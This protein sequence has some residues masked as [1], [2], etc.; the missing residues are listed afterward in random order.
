M[1]FQDALDIKKLGGFAGYQKTFVGIKFLEW[2]VKYDFADF[3]LCKRPK[4]TKLSPFKVTI[5][6]SIL[7]ITFGHL[8]QKGY[9]F[10]Y[11]LILE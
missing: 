6:I 5:S 1:N 8:M 3:N 10:L 11:I 4:N 2:P 9:N 7:N